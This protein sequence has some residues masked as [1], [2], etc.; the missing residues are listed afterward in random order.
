[1]LA[2]CLRVT[3]G[4]PQENDRFLDALQSSLEQAA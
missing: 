3:V 2:G 4:A 1:M